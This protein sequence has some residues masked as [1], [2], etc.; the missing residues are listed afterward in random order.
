[1]KWLSKLWFKQLFCK[2]NYMHKEVN[3]GYY[4]EELWLECKKCKKQKEVTY[5]M[6]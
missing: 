6:V 2:H 1:M 5:E 4:D 3:V